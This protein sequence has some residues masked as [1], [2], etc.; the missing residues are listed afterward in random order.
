VGGMT[1]MNDTAIPF[2]VTYEEI[3]L[4]HFEF[5]N[6]PIAFNF[7]AGHINDNQALVLGSEIEFK[8]G[9]KGAEL[10]FLS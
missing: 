7:P 1:D 5:R 10:N 6:I 9:D 4:A 2:G 3:I 8:V